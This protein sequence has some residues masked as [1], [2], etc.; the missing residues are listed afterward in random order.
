MDGHDRRWCYIDPASSV[1]K[2]DV[3]VRRIG[4]AKARGI[5]L[6]DYLQDEKPAAVGML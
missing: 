3:R 4:Q 2:P 5:Q 6:P 1:F